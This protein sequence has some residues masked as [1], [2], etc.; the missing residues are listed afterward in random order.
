[1]Q[2][3]AEGLWLSPGAPQR[4]ILLC[5]DVDGPY[6]KLT[7][8]FDYRDGSDVRTHGTWSIVEIPDE[9][10]SVLH[11]TFHWSNC[12]CYNM[13][14][15]KLISAGHGLWRDIHQCD[16]F[17]LLGL[18]VLT[19]VQCSL[20]A[21]SVQTKLSA[22]EFVFQIGSQNVRICDSENRQK[23]FTSNSDEAVE[24]GVRWFCPGETVKYV[25]F[26]ADT[27][28]IVI[29]PARSQETPAHGQWKC[30]SDPTGTA[31]FVTHF[32]SEGEL[33][34]ASNEPAA[35]IT[36]LRSLSQ[37]PTQCLAVTELDIFTSTATFPNALSGPALKKL[38]V[39]NHNDLHTPSSSHVTAQIIWSAPINPWMLLQS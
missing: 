19:E 3:H 10:E 17:V 12:N 33:S 2:I 22:S 26:L 16:I 9:H 4:K 18:A 25:L 32:H 28:V 13:V 30:V 38:R 5:S 6:P 24:L 14:E 35:P 31:F 37:S 8:C 34:Q 29:D 27:T 15:K 36:I 1:M 20:H 23:I 11:L 7:L 39:F 21:N